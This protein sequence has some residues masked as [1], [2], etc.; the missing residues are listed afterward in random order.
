MKTILPEKLLSCVATTTTAASGQE[1]KKSNRCGSQTCKEGESD[2]RKMWLKKGV[3][4]K[5]RERTAWVGNASVALVGVGLSYL[6]WKRIYRVS[7]VPTAP[8]TTGPNFRFVRA[9]G[10]LV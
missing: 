1:S 5:K 3:G 2:C 4:E 7:F 10:F 6:W 9:I 8:F